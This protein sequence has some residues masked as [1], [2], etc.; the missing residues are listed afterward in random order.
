MPVLF[1]FLSSTAANDTVSTAEEESTMMMANWRALRAED[2]DKM[3]ERPHERM[4]FH[5]ATRARHS[6]LSVSVLFAMPSEGESPP[7][8][9]DSGVVL[10]VR[11]APQGGPLTV[12]AVAAQTPEQREKERKSQAFIFQVDT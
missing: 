1:F 8:P 9:P 7:S 12:A 5:L 2:V 6:I 10:D 11:T 3:L 4:T